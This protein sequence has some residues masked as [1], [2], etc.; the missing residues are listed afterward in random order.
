MFP[1]SEIQRFLGEKSFEGLSKLRT[2]EE[3]RQANLEGMVHC[4]FCPFA[5]IMEDPT[6]RIFQCLNPACG[7]RSCRYCRVK[8]HHPLSCESIPKSIGTESRISK[9]EENR[10]QTHGGRGDDCGIGEE[11]QQVR[12]TVLQRRWMQ[13]DHLSMWES[14]MLYLLREC[15]D[16]RP[17]R[18]WKVSAIRRY[19]QTTTTRSGKST[20]MGSE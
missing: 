18:K 12:Q 11:V 19:G 2:E 14:T 13:Q 17:F 16:V 5:A 4:P 3:L 10:C 9:G 15:L 20:R 8:S 6:D 7:E 1:E